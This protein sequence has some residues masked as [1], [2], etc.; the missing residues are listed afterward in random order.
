[1]NISLSDYEHSPDPEQ[2]IKLSNNC[3]NNNQHEA[4]MLFAESALR[5]NLTFDQKVKVLER[6][7]ITGFYSKLPYRRN[8]GKDAC[9]FLSMTRSVNPHTRYLASQNGSWYINSATELMPQTQLQNVDFVSPEAYMPMNPSIYRWNDQL[10]MIQRTV[11]YIMTPSGHYDMR[12]DTAIKTTNW[13]LKLNADLSV[14]SSRKILPPNDL[15]TPLYGLVLGFE[16]CRLFAWQGSLWCTSTVRELNAPGHCEIVIARIEELDQET[17]MFKDWRVIHPRDIPVQ[18]Q[19]NWMPM[20]NNDKLSFIYS[21]DPVRIIDEYGTTLSLK[22]STVASDRFRGGSQAIRFH[23]AWL[24]IIHESLGMPDGRRRYVHRFVIYDDNYTVQSYSPAF[25]I[26]TLGIEF[27]AGIAINPYDSK[28]VVSF[29]I[30]DKQSWLATF[31]QQD[32][33]SILVRA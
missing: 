33:Q 5:M 12:G 8:L 9:E 17:C 13:L 2:L 19:K 26:H 25:Y 1:M 28:V 14:A 23:D 3:A 6:M 31:D 18:H 21:S 24:A 11:N 7:S 27:A 10:W 29:G 4:A 15:P 20:V 30:G 32:I 16:D 22:D